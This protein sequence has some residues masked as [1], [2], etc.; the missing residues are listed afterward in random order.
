MI[1]VPGFLYKQLHKFCSYGISPS[2]VKALVD[3]IF[4]IALQVIKISQLLL[5]LLPLSV[6]HF[7]NWLFFKRFF[8][9]VFF[10]ID[11]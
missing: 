3:L 11:L 6:W 1:V 9:V 2:L 8:G 10:L 7:R 5:R 4:R